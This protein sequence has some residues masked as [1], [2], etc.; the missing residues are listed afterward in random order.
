MIRM[1]L[2]LLVL[3]CTLFAHASF[4]DIKQA[5]IKQV[6]VY[7]LQVELKKDLAE[8]GI[9]FEDTD[10]FYEFYRNPAAEHLD[11]PVMKL[12]IEYMD[13][14]SPWCSSNFNKPKK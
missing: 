4:R 11:S 7:Q 13:I 12:A 1:L 10:A 6:R 9:D 2:F 5:A 8:Y 3:L 14:V